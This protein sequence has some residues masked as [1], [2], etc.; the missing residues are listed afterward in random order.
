MASDMLV[1][2]AAAKEGIVADDKTVTAMFDQM[3]KSAGNNQTAWKKLLLTYAASNDKELRAYLALQNLNSQLMAK[4][5]PLPDNAT[6][7]DQ[8][9]QQTTYQQY[10]QGLQS[11][12]EI[13]IEPMP[14]SVPYN[15]DMTLANA[16][17]GGS[18]G[19]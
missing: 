1:R 5:A 9:A 19:Q 2:E 16:A 17:K 15:V 4:V 18:A 3:K 13:K 6:A 12:A 10:L 8:A 7:E 14:K 11:S